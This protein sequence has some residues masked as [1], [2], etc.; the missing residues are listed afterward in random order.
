[1]R[2][3]GRRRAAPLARGAPQDRRRA[4]PRPPPL[5]QGRGHRRAPRQGPG[6]PRRPGRGRRPLTPAPPARYPDVVADREVAMT[7]ISLEDAQSRLPE[8]IARLQPGEE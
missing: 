6:P 7:R 4:R 8:L 1:R 3:R 2:A 5:P